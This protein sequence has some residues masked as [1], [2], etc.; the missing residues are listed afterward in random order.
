LFL[1]STGQAAAI[2]DYDLLVQL[3]ERKGTR[4]AMKE[5][6]EFRTQGIKMEQ[7]VE[8]TR[9]LLL[10]DVMKFAREER[11]KRRSKS[12]RNCGHERRI[13]ARKS[14]SHYPSSALLLVILPPR[15]PCQR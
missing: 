11:M 9:G 13:R 5:A 6:E 14:P 1:N 3:L 10:E 8:K 7:E 2:T 15:S 4:E 12:R